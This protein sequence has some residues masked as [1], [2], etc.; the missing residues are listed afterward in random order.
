MVCFFLNNILVIQFYILSSFITLLPLYYLLLQG[1]TLATNPPKYLLAGEGER[2]VSLYNHTGNAI[3]NGMEGS[4][5]GEIVGRKDRGENKR[6]V[7]D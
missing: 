5:V 2:I 6:G 7:V 1:K 3:V 4:R